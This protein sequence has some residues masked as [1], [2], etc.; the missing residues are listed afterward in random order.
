MKHNVQLKVGWREGG[1]RGG[2]CNMKK[3]GAAD[4]VG[5]SHPINKTSAL[6]FASL[7][8]QTVPEVQNRQVILVTPDHLRVL[9]LGNSSS[10]LCLLHDDC[11]PVSAS[12][13]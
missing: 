10:F 9:L 13:G 6:M 4:L 3:A 12:P 1:E 11:S 2:L 5:I 8:G 7:I